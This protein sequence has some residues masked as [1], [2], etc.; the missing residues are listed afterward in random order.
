MRANRVVNIDM[1]ESHSSSYEHAHTPTLSLWEMLLNA[2]LY[3]QAFPLAV[4]TRR[5]EWAETLDSHPVDNRNIA[6]SLESE[7]EVLEP[8]WDSCRL[9]SVRVE[10][11]GYTS[12]E[13]SNKLSSCDRILIVR[14]DPQTQ[15]ATM[16]TKINYISYICQ[17]QLYL[18]KIE[19]WTEAEYT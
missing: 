2:S 7:V 11:T 14:R 9:M 17:V 6:S 10:N 15:L 8:Q 13:L 4:V 3:S 19:N 18:T 5:W 16:F 1:Y 12:K